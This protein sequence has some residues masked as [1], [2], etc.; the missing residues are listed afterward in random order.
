[1]KNKTRTL[2]FQNYV[3]RTNMKKNDREIQNQASNESRQQHNFFQESQCL[4][5]FSFV[6]ILLLFAFAVSFLIII[7]IILCFV[8][9]CNRNR[10]QQDRFLELEQLEKNASQIKK[11][12]S[13]GCVC[14]D[15]NQ[16]FDLMH[17]DKKK[18]YMSDFKKIVFKTDFFHA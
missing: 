12:D 13:V 18:S 8:Q 3:Y 16:P 10:T 15:F 2:V 14:G 7:G 11:E 9:N 6:C 4:F 5:L 17:F 1:M